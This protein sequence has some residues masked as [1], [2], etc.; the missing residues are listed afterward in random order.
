M[1]RHILWQYCRRKA[2]K[3]DDFCFLCGSLFIYD[4]HEKKASEWRLGLQ[5]ILQED[6]TV[7][8]KN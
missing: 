3:F 2:A 4:L 6:H 1:K 8:M 5:L 7:D